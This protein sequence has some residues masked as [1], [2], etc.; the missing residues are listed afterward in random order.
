MTYSNLK[1]LRII[2][3]IVFLDYFIV[4]L[5]EIFFPELIGSVPLLMS[6]FE[7]TIGLFAL[8]MSRNVEKYADF[9]VI[10]IL[11]EVLVVLGS[12]YGVFF[13]N[14]DIYIAGTVGAIHLIYLVLIILFCDKSIFTKFLNSK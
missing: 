3:I 14:L 7:I 13:N 11:N 12:F 4:G 5:L 9:I 1:L 8:N 6:L 10:L 2:L